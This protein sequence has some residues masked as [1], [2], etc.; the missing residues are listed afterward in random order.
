MT[1]LPSLPPLQ[2]APSQSVI[3]ECTAPVNIA[4]VKYW[5]KRNEELILPIN[6]SLSGTIHQDTMC[7]HTRIIASRE[8]TED[9][10]ILNG[11][12]EKIKDKGRLRTVINECLAR[13]QPL[14]S[15]IKSVDEWKQYRLRIESVN[16]F[17]TAAG[18]A[19]SAAGLACLTATL[20]ALY[21]VKES[22]EGE[23]SAIAR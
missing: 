22:Y 10:M 15:H 1:S 3:A 12:E 20:A 18:L 8:Y 19:S 14:E 7:A 21:H 13:A 2:H 9:V 11:K 23:L 5:G 17:P 16:N 6:D 4:I